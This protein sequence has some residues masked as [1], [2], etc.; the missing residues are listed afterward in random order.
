[1]RPCIDTVI[2]EHGA[3]PEPDEH[4]K[5]PAPAEKAEDA[6]KAEDAAPRRR[7]KLKE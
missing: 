2:K 7:G 3:E 6:D 5:P 1:M 4:E